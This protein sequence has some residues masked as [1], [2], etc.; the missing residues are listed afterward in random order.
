VTRVADGNLVSGGNVENRAQAPVALKA[1]VIQSIQLAPNPAR[2]MLT[3]DFALSETANSYSQLR[4]LNSQGQMM[5]NV[6]VGTQ[7][8]ANRYQFDV[9]GWAPGMYVVY[10]NNG[11]EVKAVRFLV[12]R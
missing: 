8:G 2:E 9:T 12:A 1:E 11:K 4:V 6:Q 5:R 10:L 7:A 3:V